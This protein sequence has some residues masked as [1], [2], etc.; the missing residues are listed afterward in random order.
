MKGFTFIELLI[1]I[2][3]LGILAAIVLGAI[4][5]KDEKTAFMQS[6]SEHEAAYQCE[7]KWKQMH[8]D[9]ITVYAPFNK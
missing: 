3:I 2:A 4:V 8:P 5:G 9:P 6:C 7:Y 1:I